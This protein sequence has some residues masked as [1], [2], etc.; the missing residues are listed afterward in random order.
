MSDKEMDSSINMI[1]DEMRRKNLN[2]YD[3]AGMLEA[4][5]PDSA[6]EGN[7]LAEAT[8]LRLVRQAGNNLTVDLKLLLRYRFKRSFLQEFAEVLLTKYDLH[9]PEPAAMGGAAP[10]AKKIEN[11]PP[12]DDVVY[13]LDSDD[14]G[15]PSEISGK[16]FREADLAYQ[17]AKAARDAAEAEYMQDLTREAEQEERAAKRPRA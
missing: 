8:A 17:A 6:V 15:K 4:A 3:L 12:A 11:P 10:A 13:L 2:V 7:P 9:K 16:R 1:I 5:Q 14:E